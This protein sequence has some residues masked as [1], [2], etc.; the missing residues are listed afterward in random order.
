MKPTATILKLI[1]LALLLIGLVIGFLF[2]QVWQKNERP[3]LS[4]SSWNQE[5]ILIGHDAQLSLTISAPW[6]R[7]ITSPSPHSYP[8][9]LIPLANKAEL[10]KGTLSLSGMR[11]W[12]LTVPFVATDTK[13]LT[14]LT[15]TFP[16]SLTVPLPPL[17]IT[18]PENLPL[19]PSNPNTFLT[20]E[21]PEIEEEENQETEAKKSPWLW[22]LLLL[23]IPL[24][25]LLLLLL[26]RTGIIK[27]T[28][29]SLKKTS[30]ISP[31]LPTSL[32][33]SNSPTTFPT[34]PKPQ[35]HSN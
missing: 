29:K 31:S 1:L 15:A 9:H 34:Q 32:T 13:D 8:P 6:H 14:G 12:D 7:E 33:R 24:L 35:S 30:T 10:S 19:V 11:T 5:E 26:K 28:P 25:F 27:T 20:E 17:T 3:T 23:L 21:K 4:E 16:I 22:A 18:V 2:F